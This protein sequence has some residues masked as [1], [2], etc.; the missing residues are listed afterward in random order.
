VTER[1]IYVELPD[2]VEGFIPIEELGDDYYIYDKK[3]YT[4]IGKHHKRE[5]R[6]GQPMDVKVDKVDLNLS[7][8]YFKPL[9]S[10]IKRVPRRNR[11]RW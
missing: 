3:H 5:Y 10:R 6:M 7:M 2:T 9:V 1:G 8:I 4:L 11:I